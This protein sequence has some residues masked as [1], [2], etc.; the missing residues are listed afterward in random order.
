MFSQTV[1]GFYST[2]R[3][4]GQGKPVSRVMTRVYRAPDAWARKL[5]LCV[6][7]SFGWLIRIIWGYSQC[8]GRQTVSQGECGQPCKKG[9]HLGSPD[10][11]KETSVSGQPLGTTALPQTKHVQTISSNNRFSLQTLVSSGLTT[12]YSNE[13]NG[14]VGNF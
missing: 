10:L 13:R 4:F 11:S 12:S 14:M 8:S 9:E 6:S 5:R 3:A 1:T 7:F 2:I